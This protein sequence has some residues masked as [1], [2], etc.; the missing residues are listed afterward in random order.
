MGKL[1]EKFLLSIAAIVGCFRRRVYSVR[2]SSSRDY[3][4]VGCKGGTSATAGKKS[5][6]ISA[7][8]NGVTY[9]KRVFFKQQYLLATHVGDTVIVTAWATEEDAIRH[10]DYARRDG[11][12][13]DYA[14]AQ[15]I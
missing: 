2:R 1:P 7:T 14:L 10:R 4:G 5:R 3:G 15:T 11:D 13:S 9:E 8:I 12:V 6:V